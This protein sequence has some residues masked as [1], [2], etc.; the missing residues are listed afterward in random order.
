[1]AAASAAPLLLLLALAWLL[2]WVEVEPSLDW[3]P[4]PDCVTFGGVVV[5]ANALPIA[6]AMAAAINVLFIS[7]SLMSCFQVPATL[8]PEA[9]SQA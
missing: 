1:M 7:S 6:K 2:S 5:C 9:I 4:G 8:G 3:A